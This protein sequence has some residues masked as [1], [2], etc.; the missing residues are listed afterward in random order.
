LV[1]FDG[2]CNL[3]NASVRFIVR[4]D[5]K[6]RF[7]FASLQSSAGQMYLER[8]RMPADD[9]DT[10]VLIDHENCYTRSTAALRVLRM[11]DGWLALGYAL[12]FLPRPVRDWLYNLIAKN[13]YRLFG[14]KEQ[15][16]VPTAGL[17]KRFLE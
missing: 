4:H 3:C 9:F 7:R 17:R 1:L 14:K 15:C 16:M 12:I 5:R 11:L 13:R 6:E 8:F 10:F 2:V